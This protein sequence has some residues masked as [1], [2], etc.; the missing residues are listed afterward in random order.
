M[1]WAAARP[2]AANDAARTSRTEPR[3]ALLTVDRVVRER[4]LTGRR[5]RLRASSE[6]SG[7]GGKLVARLNPGNGR[8]RYSRSCRC[9]AGKEPTQVDGETTTM[10]EQQKSE[11]IGGKL[12]GWFQERLVDVEQ[13]A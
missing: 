9:K 1:S 11:E 2:A 8:R 10:S 3:A 7:R 6:S 4:S 5:A 12:K 13:R